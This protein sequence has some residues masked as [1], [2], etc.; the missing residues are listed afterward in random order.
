MRHYRSQSRRQR[1]RQR[2]KSHELTK[3]SKDLSH[4]TQVTINPQ[5]VPTDR[6][7]ILTSIESN[8]IST[9]MSLH[10]TPL[11]M[12][13]RSI[14]SACTGLSYLGG[15]TPRSVRYQMTRKTSNNGMFSDSETP[16][17]RARRPIRYPISP[18]HHSNNNTPRHQQSY[19]TLT[20]KRPEGT[21][22]YEASRKV[23]EDV[24]KLSGNEN[25]RDFIQ[26]L[27]S[28]AQEKFGGTHLENNST[29]ASSPTETNES[30]TLDSGYQSTKQLMNNDEYAVIIKNKTVD[31]KYSERRR[32][33][34]SFDKQ[35]E[36]NSF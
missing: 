12:S 32:S 23:Y 31:K 34:S 3:I 33:Y 15:D 28:L 16:R 21:V 29:M 11:M 10:R 26:V 27:D 1:T 18:Y 9:P 19:A 30:I 22:R 6:T 25:L 17:T 36:E 7:G 14:T 2:S 13:N 8:L 20:L 4:Q 5:D 24:E 35:I